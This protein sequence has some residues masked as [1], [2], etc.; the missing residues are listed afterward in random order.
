MSF[1]ISQHRSRLINELHS[2]V[3]RGSKLDKKTGKT[4]FKEERCGWIS[5]R[6]FRNHLLNGLQHAIRVR[7]M[8]HGRNAKVPLIL[9]LDV[10]WIHKFEDWEHAVFEK[11]CVYILYIE[12]GTTGW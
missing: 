10:A 1:V 8:K 7:D 5:K 12:G 6:I 3:T 9:F 11:D 2:A 4:A